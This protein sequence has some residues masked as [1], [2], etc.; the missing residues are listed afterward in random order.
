M[1][2]KMKDPLKTIAIFANAPLVFVVVQKILT[3]LSRDAKLGG[4]GGVDTT[5]APLVY[6]CEQVGFYFILIND[7][8]SFSSI[9]DLFLYT[10]HMSLN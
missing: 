3:I 8:E 2:K 1:Y 5:K 9:I 7:N 10:H 4:G 6:D